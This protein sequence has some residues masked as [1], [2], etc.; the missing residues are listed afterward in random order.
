MFFYISKILSYILNPLGWIV[1]LLFITL[2]VRKPLR[3]KRYLIIS[4]IT[5]LLFSNPFLGDEA[6]RV[7]EKPLN[8]VNDT[9]YT[10]GILLGGDIISY[11]K[12]SDRVIFRSGADRLLQTIS[13]YKSGKIKRIV[14]SGGSGHLLYRDRTEASFIK[15]Y[16]AEIGI[17]SNDIIVENMSKNTFENAKFTA[18][19][20]RSNDI[21]DTVL[22][23]TSSM[24]MRRAAACFRKQ[25][26]AVEEFPTSKITGNRITNYD[27]LIVPSLTTLKNWNVLIHEI[28]GFG[29]YKLM[30]YC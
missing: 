20:L 28:M 8:K 6:I 4:M 16:L 18:K 9:Y 7:W 29:M 17:N 27:H 24:H 11:D 14:I 3:K 5:L 23:I 22:L 2:F 13:L 15:R 26:I 30:G 25:G 1:I 10:A 12:A 19:I 21:S